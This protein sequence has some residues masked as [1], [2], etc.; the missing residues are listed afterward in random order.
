MASDQL[1]TRIED[2]LDK[3]EVMLAASLGVEG[4]IDNT[5]YESIFGRGAQSTHHL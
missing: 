1:V 3:K 2:T 4:T 5:S